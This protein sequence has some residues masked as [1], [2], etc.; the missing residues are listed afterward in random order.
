MA[1]QQQPSE[2]PSSGPRVL[3]AGVGY[4][5]ALA[6]ELAASRGAT[7]FGLLRSPRE[8]PAG[9]TP[10][11][12]DVTAR[13][14]LTELPPDLDTIVYAVAPDAHDDEAYE[15]TYPGGL[16]NL[17]A[18][19][20]GR[21]PRVILVSSTAVYDQSGGE[22]IDD[23]SAANAP[24]PK[25]LRLRRA[26][27]TALASHPSSL[28]VRAS[29][30]Y[31]PGRTSLARRLAAEAPKPELAGLFSCRIHRVD[32]ASVLVEAVF[33]ASLSGILLATDT[34]PATFGELHDF[35]RAR[36]VPPPDSAQP[37]RRQ[38]AHRSRRMIPARLIERGFAFRYPSFR[39]GYGELFATR[40]A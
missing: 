3:V 35:L 26:E 6:A 38:R 24:E 16:S 14:S 1:E 2:V 13:G 20:R 29:G 10:T 31:G 12:G 39:E 27:Q 11:S 30:I 36:D 4:V 33:D 28:V 15:R 19:T 7:V 32:L 22:R 5:G 40:S 34:T 23:A 25:A 9:V 8:L 17:L 37:S 21:A 18:A